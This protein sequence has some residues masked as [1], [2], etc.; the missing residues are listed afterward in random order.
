MQITKSLAQDVAIKMTQN[1]RDKKI[2]LENQLSEIIHGWVMA[3][4]P[5]EIMA[6]FNSKNKGYLQLTSGA[7]LT[8]NGYN[9]D[10]IYCREFPIYNTD[11]KAISVTREMSEK[12]SPLTNSIKDY[13][14]E[15]KDLKNKIE[16]A[17]FNLKTKNKVAE[18]FPEALPFFPVK[19][20]ITAVMVDLTQLRDFAKTVVVEQVA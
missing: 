1:L 17:I 2:A 3:K 14:K 5:K 18:Q 7:R 6:V 15:I 10:S 19:E 12:I 20:N 8:G 16:E 9:W 13:E 11:S 4:V